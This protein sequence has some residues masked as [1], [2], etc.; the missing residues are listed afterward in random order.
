MNQPIKYRGMEIVNVIIEKNS[1]QVTNDSQNFKVI[2]NDYEPGM[3]V[4]IG[5]T[6]D[7]AISDFKEW[8]LNKY[9]KEIELNI[10]V[11]LTI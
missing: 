8:W 2:P 9:D 6:L 11:T 1:V 5:A 3:P 10:L 7:D 4:G